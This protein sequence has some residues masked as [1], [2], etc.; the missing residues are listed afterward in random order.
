MSGFCLLPTNNL[1]LTRL[2]RCF[3]AAYSDHC[4]SKHTLLDSKLIDGRKQTS[5]SSRVSEAVL[6]AVDTESSDTNISDMKGQ[7]LSVPVISDDDDWVANCDEKE[8]IPVLEDVGCVLKVQF[9][10]A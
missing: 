2:T 7:P 8:Y 10:T 4:A 5:S 6:S 1:I 3:R 9:I